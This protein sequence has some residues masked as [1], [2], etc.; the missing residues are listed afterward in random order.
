MPGGRFPTQSAWPDCFGFRGG[1]R[2]VLGA[3]GDGCEGDL[4]VDELRV[5]KRI[6]R[7]KSEGGG[8][9]KKR[10]K[11]SPESSGWGWDANFM[12]FDPSTMVFET[13]Y[14]RSAIRLSA[15][16]RKEP[17]FDGELVLVRIGDAVCGIGPAGS[18]PCP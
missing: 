12:G 5:R 13:S 1:P 17:G 4:S 14:S 8:E 15:S 7:A 6:Q 9:K 18:I 11:S 16:L 2:G 10:K 3:V